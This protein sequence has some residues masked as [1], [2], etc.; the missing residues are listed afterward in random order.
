MNVNR[1]SIIVGTLLII[2]IVAMGWTLGISPKLAEADATVAQQRTVETENAA[3]EAELVV[4]RKLF[5][6]LELLRTE[7]GA[8]QNG[9]PAATGGENFIDQLKAAADGA[10]VTITSVTVGEPAGYLPLGAEE[11]SSAE[12]ESAP[13][14]GAT[15]PD[16]DSTTAPAGATLVGKLFTVELTVSVAGP[17]AAVFSFIG[18]M[19]EGSRLFVANGVQYTADG[20]AESGTVTGYILVVNDPMAFVAETPAA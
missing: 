17:S 11:G 14:A 6:N 1:L 10:G 5:S 20:A 18:A 7:Y 12:P 9:I 4:L 19:Q 15:S 13:E 3:Q 2:V 8:L 16:T